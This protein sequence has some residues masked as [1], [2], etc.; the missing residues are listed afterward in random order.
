MLR[1]MTLKNTPSII[2]CVLYTGKDTKIQM[3]NKTPEFKMSRIMKQM[4]VYLGYVLIIMLSIIFVSTLTS[5]IWSTKH[6]TRLG[7][8]GFG[9]EDFKK[10]NL[11][12]STLG[13]WFLLQ[14]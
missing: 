2:G 5:V 9:S 4:N 12:L 11:W 1:G 8:L 14:S 7:Y 13:T 3:S 10:S 6:L